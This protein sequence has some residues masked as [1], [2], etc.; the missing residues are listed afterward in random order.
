[1]H[2]SGIFFKC[3]QHRSHQE[4]TF[5]GTEEP[6]DLQQGWEMDQAQIVMSQFLNFPLKEDEPG[7]T[8]APGCRP[9]VG[10][11]RL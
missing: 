3:Y 4:A 5:E 2:T 11:R 6:P 9:D 7:V 10:E 1:M 8:E